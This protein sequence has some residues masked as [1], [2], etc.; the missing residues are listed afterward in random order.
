MHGRSRIIGPVFAV[1]LIAVLPLL[2]GRVAPPRGAHAAETPPKVANPH[3]DYKEDCSLCHSA[4]GWKPVR[5][6]KKFDH[7]RFLPLSGAHAAVACMQCHKGLD[8]AMAPT[9]CVDCHAD[10]H[11]GELG[12]DCARCHGTR[13]FVDRND[14]IRLHRVTRFPL[15]GAHATVDCEMCHRLAAPGDLTYVN[16]AT[17]CASCHMEDYQATKEPDHATAGFPTDCAA[18]HDDVAWSRARFDHASTAFP[19]TGAHVPLPCDRCHVG[20]VYTGLSPECVSC[21]QGDYDG[22]NDPPHAASGFS[23]SCTQCHNTSNWG[24]ANFNHAN[25]AFPLTGAHVPLAC[26]ACHASGVYAGLPSACVSC[27]QADYD[28]TSEPAHA[29]AGFSTECTQCHNTSRWG[30]ANFNHAG[31]A[32]PLTGAHVPLAC[33]SCHAG[34]VYA[35]LPSSCVSCH[36]GDYNATTDPAHAAAGFPTDC[37]QCHNTTRWG[38]A[39]FDHNTFFPIY[40]GRHAGTWNTCGDCHTNAANYA[41]FSCLGCHPHSDRTETDGHHAG[42]NG[43]S[44]TSAACYNCHPRGTKE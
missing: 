11:N 14:H 34:G 5:I 26:N 28:G 23:T 7:E 20:G 39:Q 18:C 43:Y 36:Q 13:S 37:T 17:D 21:H 12:S 10:V 38:G 35:G 15:S 1:A 27:H 2:L 16:T 41:D 40:S 31:T 29:A 42:M 44:Y 8:F 33:S 19:L 6:G 3:G 30:D 9:A 22:T 4:K 24:D 32:F 25:T